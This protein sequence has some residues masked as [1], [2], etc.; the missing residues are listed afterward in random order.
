MALD[1]NNG[2]FPI[3]VCICESECADSWK[4]FLAILREWLNIR[5]QSQVTFMTDRQKAYILGWCDS[6]ALCQAYIC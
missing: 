4:W 3:A 5:N 1:A 2:I 6:K